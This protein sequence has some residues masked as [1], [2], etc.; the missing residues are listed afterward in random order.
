MHPQLERLVSSKVII[1]AGLGSTMNNS[2]SSPHPNLSQPMWVRRRR[3]VRI[4][5]RRLDIA[6]LPFLEPDGAMYHLKLDG[7]LIPCESISY[8]I[9]DA[10]AGQELV[11]IPSNPSSPVRDYVARARSLADNGIHDDGATRSS[12]SAIETRRM[13]VRAISELKE[14]ISRIYFT[15]MC[16]C[17]H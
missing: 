10:D 15:H 13:L 16:I 8:D 5:R 14:G 7:S 12:P 17:N 11:T 9:P 2:L 3:W 1:P 4:M 6:P